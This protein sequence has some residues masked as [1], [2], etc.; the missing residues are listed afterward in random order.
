[1]RR[2][3]IEHQGTTVEVFAEKIQGQLWYHINGETRW[4]TPNR[5]KRKGAG[6]AELD[7]CIL[8]APM[9]GQT[10]KIN[11]GVGAQARKGETVIV[12]E[13]M[14]MEYALKAQV[15]SV[16]LEIAVDVGEQV[17]LDQV[18]ARMSHE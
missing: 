9:P 14:K 6:S 15:D 4:Y 7:P 16:V 1:M 13:A 10:I 2:L 8:K 17:S 3:R 12:L 11:K 18:L 5:R